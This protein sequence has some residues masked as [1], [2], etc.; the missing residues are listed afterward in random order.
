MET[1]PET[2]AM[3]SCTRSVEQARYT[4]LDQAEELAKNFFLDEPDSI[5]D[6]VLLVAGYRLRRWISFGLSAIKLFRC[7]FDK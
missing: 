5:P 4:A 1:C 7:S 2:H 6:K 3:S